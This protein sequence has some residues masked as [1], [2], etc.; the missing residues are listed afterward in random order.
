[1]ILSL[2]KSKN[3]RR[4]GRGKNGKEK[5]GKN[6]TGLGCTTYKTTMPPDPLHSSSREKDEAFKANDLRCA[7]SGRRR[8]NS[9]AGGTGNYCQKLTAD[10]VAW[11]RSKKKEGS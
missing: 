10:P 11:N 6:S 5:K 3:R 1:M 4:E 2:G 9:S 8:K 7:L